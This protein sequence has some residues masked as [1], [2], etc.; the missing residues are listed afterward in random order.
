MSLKEGLRFLSRNPHLIISFSG[1]KPERFVPPGKQHFVMG[2]IDFMA[3][4]MNQHALSVPDPL[5]KF[6]LWLGHYAAIILSGI[7]KQRAGDFFHSSWGQYPIDHPQG[8]ARP[9]IGGAVIME[10][11]LRSLDIVVP[12]KALLAGGAGSVKAFFSMIGL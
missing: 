1:K 5:N 6:F 11:R 2:T 7:E 4:A 8:L 10:K 3:G 9:A 12:I